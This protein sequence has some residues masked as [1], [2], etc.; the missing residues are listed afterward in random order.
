MVIAVDIS[1]SE[2]N[3]AAW[4]EGIVYKNLSAIAGMYP[5]HHFVFI[6]DRTYGSN[7]AATGNCTFVIAGPG[8]NNQILR[9]FWYNYKLPSL[10][11]RYKADIFI[12]TNGCC[13]TNTKLPQ[14]LLITDGIFGASRQLAG[15]TSE[16]FV[17][18]QLPLFLDKANRIIA[19]SLNGRG[20][21]IS[22]LPAAAEK[23]TVVYPAAGI[24]FS[25]L[26]WEE[27]ELVK[28]QYTS[29][30]EYFLHGGAINTK[31]QLVYL[32]KAFS[33]FKKRQKSN[34]Q[35]LLAGHVSL[36]KNDLKQTLATYKYRDEVKLTGYLSIPAFARLLAGAYAMVHTG[37]GTQLPQEA[38][39]CGVPL[40]VTDTPALQEICGD[41]ALYINPGNPI[42]IAG[43]MML[44]FKDENQRNSMIKKGNEQSVPYSAPAALIKLAEAVLNTCTLP[45]QAG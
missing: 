8:V 6:F 26:D 38:M 45:T 28:G 19:T 20:H 12:G 25:T 7:A 21:I 40:L 33:L 44:V 11:R 27:R 1:V 29:G 15:T 22:A 36:P 3:T 39:I 32:L 16:R 18:K 4:R 10:L 41:A 37:T 9:H 13:S 5:Q 34:M 23:I 43:Q 30:K 42:A 14:C 24:G 31:N 35:L 17:K 2:K